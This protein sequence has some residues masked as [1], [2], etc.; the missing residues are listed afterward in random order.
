MGTPRK[1]G[2]EGQRTSEDIRAEAL[3]NARK[4]RETIGEDTIQKIAEA[5]RKKQNNPVE[6]A[7]AKIA[8]ANPDRV[9]DELKWMLESKD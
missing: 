3:A 6:I 1:M 5:M 7:K 9:L 8:A 2:N 4:A